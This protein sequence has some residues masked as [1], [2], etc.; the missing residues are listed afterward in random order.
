ME[1]LP[2]GS[3]LVGNRVSAEVSMEA[4]VSTAAEAFTE[5]AAVGGNSA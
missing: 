5:E 3:P 1:E 4:E 2:E